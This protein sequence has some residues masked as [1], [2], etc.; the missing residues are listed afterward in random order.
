M[1]LN[2]YEVAILILVESFLQY[3]YVDGKGRKYFSRNPYFSGILSAIQYKKKK[4]KKMWRKLCRNPYFSG[5]LS[6]IFK[7]AYHE[8][9]IEESQSLF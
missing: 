4:K 8:G 5:I 6:A 2:Y 9:V 7:L 3:E 1:I